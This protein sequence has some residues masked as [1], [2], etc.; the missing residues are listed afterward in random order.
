MV[1]PHLGPFAGLGSA[2]EEPA[3]RCTVEMFQFTGPFQQT[4]VTVQQPRMSPA[5]LIHQFPE[6]S[7]LHRCTDPG[8]LGHRNRKIVVGEQL[9]AVGGFAEFIRRVRPADRTGTGKFAHL[10]QLQRS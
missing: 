7:F 4:A 3:F 6:G 9:L 2:V 5:P 8:Y 1:P 10:I